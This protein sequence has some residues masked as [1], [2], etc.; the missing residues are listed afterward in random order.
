VAVEVLKGTE[1]Y[2]SLYCLR[3]LVSIADD[4]L[5]QR[6]PLFGRHWAFLRHFS[7]KEILSVAV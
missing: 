2:D 3:E 6:L 1:P 5:T 4:L 7:G